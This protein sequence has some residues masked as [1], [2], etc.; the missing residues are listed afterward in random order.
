MGPDGL[1]TCRRAGQVFVFNS[2]AKAVETK[3]DGQPVQIGP[4]AIWPGEP[5]R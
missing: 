4:Y 3:V 2:T 5:V 1:W